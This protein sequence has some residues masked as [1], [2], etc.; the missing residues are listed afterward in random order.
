[1]QDDPYVLVLTSGGIDSTACI[2]FYKKINFSVE[3]FFVDYGQ[4]ARSKELNAIRRVTDHFQVKLF[5]IKVKSYK[6]FSSGEVVGRNAFLIFTGLLN[7]SRNSGIIAIGVHAKVPYYDSSTEFVRQ[8]Q[9]ILEQYSQ[10]AIKLGAPLMGLKKRE[11]WD[12]C[13]AENVPINLTY[14]CELG[15]NQPC[16]EC[17]SCLDLEELYASKKS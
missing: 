7:F 11:I 10:S 2:N 12:Y 17:T 14:S 9:G 6:K 5:T 13:L 8:V 16:G 1:M 4:R 3:A 15:R